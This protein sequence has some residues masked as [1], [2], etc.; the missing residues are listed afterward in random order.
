MDVRLIQNLSA[1]TL[2]SVPYRWVIAMQLYDLRSI[3]PHWAFML[4]RASSRFL[5]IDPSC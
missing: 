4:V 1:H 5:E 2:V 3:R